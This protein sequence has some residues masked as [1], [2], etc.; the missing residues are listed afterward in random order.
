VVA[1]IGG[2]VELVVVVLFGD[3]V[4]RLTP[5]TSMNVKD[6]LIGKLALQVLKIFA[7]DHA[8]TLS[9]CAW[10]LRHYYYGFS[11]LRPWSGSRTGTASQDA[12]RLNS[13]G[14]LMGRKLFYGNGGRFII[15]SQSGD[16]RLK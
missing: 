5:T 6:W 15:S 13:S 16:G 8:A 4:L 3:I 10:L 7:F 11:S 12:G 9:S 14:T 2:P 1:V